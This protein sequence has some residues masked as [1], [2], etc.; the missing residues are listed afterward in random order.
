MIKKPLTEHKSSGLNCWI[1]KRKYS[2]VQAGLCTRV[3]LVARRE[4][5]EI[6]SIER[7]KTNLRASKAP[8]RF[9]VWKN[10]VQEKHA[11][12]S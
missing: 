6:R 4:Q 7:Y 3:N 11:R 2:H 8:P 12:L 1:C 10:S 5:L 9:V